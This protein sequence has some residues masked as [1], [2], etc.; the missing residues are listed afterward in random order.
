MEICI[1]SIYHVGFTYRKKKIEKRST[2]SHSDVNSSKLG[3]YGPQRSACTE[4]VNGLY[5][6][7]EHQNLQ[8]KPPPA[9]PKVFLL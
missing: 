6:I 7:T 5:L 9:C 8:N 1:I 2:T 3:I 4:P